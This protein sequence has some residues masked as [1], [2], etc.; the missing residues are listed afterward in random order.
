[1]T[2]SVGSSGERWPGPHC[3]TDEVLFNLF[4]IRDL[5]S[6]KLLT[7]G[8]E[9]DEKALD[10]HRDNQCPACLLLPRNPV[11]L[12]GCD[13]FLTYCRDCIRKMKHGAPEQMMAKCAFCH[14]PSRWRGAERRQ[15][16]IQSLTFPCPHCRAPISFGPSDS[17][18]MAHMK[19]CREG[20]P[21]MANVRL[22]ARLDAYA[23]EEEKAK[24]QQ[25]TRRAQLRE[26]SDVVEDQENREAPQCSEQM[27]RWDKETRK[28]FYL[29][30]SRNAT[31]GGKCTQHRD[32]WK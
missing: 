30:C 7:G 8:R 21:A 26:D 29:R 6:T 11:D 12:Y 23:E 15:Q 32:G 14:T 31:L 9:D 22:W 10:V 18:A 4:G 25:K 3:Y 28:K 2:S 13:C 1:M 20:Q 16:L 19:I 17:I 5:S 24:R 27:P